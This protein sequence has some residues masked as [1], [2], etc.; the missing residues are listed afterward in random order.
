MFNNAYRIAEIVASGLPPTK[1]KACEAYIQAVREM[2]DLNGVVDPYVMKQLDK[3]RQKRHDDAAATLGMDRHT[4]SRF[5]G[6]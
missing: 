2:D 3:T 6:L 4:F 5:I 1:R